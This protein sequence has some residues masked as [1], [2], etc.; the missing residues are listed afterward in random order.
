MFPQAVGLGA[1]WDRALL[2]AVGAAVSTEVRALGA[3]RNVWAPVVN[4]LRDPRWG[5][6]EEGYSEDPYMVAELAV[7]YCTG[8]RG[9][10]PTVWRTAPVLKHSLAYNMETGRDTVSVTL[11][12]R[13]LHEYEL[14]G[15]LAPLRA[16]VAAG[17]M[18]GYNLVDGIPNH[19]HP[20]LAVLRAVTPDLVVCSDA[21]APSNL[22]RQ[23]PSHAVSHA[24]ALRAGVDSYTDNG[25][26]AGPTVARFTEALALDLVTAGDVDT[27]VGRVLRMRA[28]TGEFTPADDP[29]TGIPAD[30]VAGPAHASL[31]ARAAHSRPGAAEERRGHPAVARV[32]AGRGDR[33]PRRP[34]ADRLVQRHPCRTRSP[35][36]TRCG[37]GS[38][39]RT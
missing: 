24:A 9:E 16:G 21:Q 1:S 23:Y 26:D 22:I 15:F 28:A 11:P 36:P 6:N 37:P 39:P 20:L 32:R 35:W 34:G 10:H 30:V 38:A 12:E 14:P 19:V 25:T 3:S 5:R 29:Y 2:R 7:A 33:A 13:V 8:L 17:V 31:A 18:P 27:A 4:P